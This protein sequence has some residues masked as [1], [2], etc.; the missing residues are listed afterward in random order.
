MIG[1]TDKE[2][3]S[4]SI[5]MQKIPVLSKLKLGYLNTEIDLGIF[6]NKD[7]DSII[8]KKNTSAFH[9]SSLFTIL[10]ELDIDTIILC[11]C[12]TSG[13]VRETVVDGI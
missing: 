6:F 5:W 10:S 11:G 8:I 9:K 1:Y 3:N 4:L 2:I 7:L 13:C 12:T